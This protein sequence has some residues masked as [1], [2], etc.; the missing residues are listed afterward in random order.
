[1]NIQKIFIS[2]LVVFFLSFFIFNVT[3]F[4]K[5]ITQNNSVNI[6]EDYIWF[7]EIVNSWSWFLTQKI[8]ESQIQNSKIY[9]E[10]INFIDRVYF[11][12]WKYKKT[13]ND[14]ELNFLLGPGLYLFDI[15]DLSY[16][17]TIKDN[18]FIIKPKSPGK[19]FIDNRNL[20]D[21]KVL[22]FDSLLDFSLL[23]SQDKKEMTKLVL[24][25]RMFF[26][27][28]SIRNKFLKNAD[29]LRIE[30]ISRIFYL[31]ENFLNNENTLNK[32]F[33]KKIYP[34]NSDNLSENFLGTS[35]KILYS[36][37]EFEKYNESNIWFLK[38]SPLSGLNFI[39]KYFILFFNNKKKIVYYKKNILNILWEFFEDNIKD[40]SKYKE[41]ILQNL[42]QIKKINPDEYDNF[43]KIILFYYKNLL[44]VNSLE[45][46]DNAIMLSDIIIKIDW[47]NLKNSLS[48][49]SFYLNKIYSINNNTSSKT[50][51]QAHL[52]E[53]LEDFLKENKIQ[54]LEK[55]ND[56]VLK[57]DYLSFF[58]K[59]IFLYNM[60]FADNQTI[61]DIFW[62]IKTYLDINKSLNI[63][64]KNTLK[65]ETLIIEY[66]SVLNKILVEV[67]NSFFEK[68]LN[69]RWLL[70]L[71]QE[72]WMTN[73]LVKNFNS[74][75]TTFFNF[76]TKN[77]SILSQKNAIYESMYQEQYN[78]YFEYYTALY[79]YPEYLIKYDKIKIDLLN[80]KTLLEEWKD[81]VLNQENFTSFISQFEWI[82]TSKMTFRIISNKYYKVNNLYV[83][84]E[85]FS[86]DLYP[87]ESNRMDNIF[88]NWQKLSVSYELD[89]IKE[90]LKELFDSANDEER[91]KFDFKKFF[92]NTF[93]SD[94]EVVVNKFVWEQYKQEDKIISLFKRDK[95]FWDLGDFNVLKWF[96]E[97]NYND[98]LVS[99]V[100]DKYDTF[101]SKS[102][103]RT[104][105][106]VLWTSQDIIW[107]LNADYVFSNTDHYFKNIKI[108]FYDKSY[109]DNWQEMFLFWWKEFLI[110]RNINT[111]NFKDEMNKEIQNIFNTN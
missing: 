79:N 67:R 50:F 45:Y 16:N 13:Q 87:T 97:I 75:M 14:R 71:N 9:V 37:D 32:L 25:P 109:Y 58:L 91:D 110:S 12:V 39:N 104:K 56:L 72:N 55:S 38:N 85:R 2:F 33:Y 17:Y 70:L 57:L 27:F 7:S 80:A 35:L 48:H 64:Y 40:N 18:S 44:K 8:K 111:L 51:L 49:S 107:I 76:Y 108:K 34:Q 30:S 90:D 93:F 52:W 98:V 89:T 61:D 31:S 105:V 73:N 69:G 83:N 42:E 23:D 47:N 28:N 3:Y 10:N 99:L 101:I 15:Y 102:I 21:V 11:S 94:N 24:Y 63:Y 36:Q 4:N 29:L 82:D 68:D 59:N 41:E 20:N 22:S 26:W 74:I 81:I 1:M 92:I 66:Y 95:L 100:W 86:F 96:L 46:V 54:N 65:T 5:N 6:W 84:G 19:I 78:K 53:Y 77:K 43:K 106:D 60:T 88:K 103:L 62:I